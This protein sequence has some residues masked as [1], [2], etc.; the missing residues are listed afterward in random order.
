M[1]LM[2]YVRGE[3]PT[4]YDEIGKTNKS[5]DLSVPIVWLTVYSRYHFKCAAAIDL[6]SYCNLSFFFNLASLFSLSLSHS[7]SV[8]VYVLSLFSLSCMPAQPYC[9][10]YKY[11]NMGICIRTI[12]TS[13]LNQR[14]WE[15]NVLCTFF[16]IFILFIIATNYRGKITFQTGNRIVAQEPNIKGIM[17][18]ASEF[19]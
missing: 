3:D 12:A 5:V 11:G 9:F 6:T 1:S 10:T 14:H 16:F 15:D 7:F 4:R 19:C 8:S 18:V 2:S 17:W 13:W